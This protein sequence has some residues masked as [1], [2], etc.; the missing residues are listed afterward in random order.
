MV[1]SCLHGVRMQQDGQQVPA[2]AATMPW[3]DRLLFSMFH[4]FSTA[5]I[6]NG[7]LVVSL[8]DGRAFEYG[9]S[10]DVMPAM[11]SAPSWM[12]LPPKQCAMV[13]HNTDMFFKVITRHDSGLG[14]A[15]MNGDFDTDD[16]GAFMAVVTANARNIEASRGILGALNRI[17][18]K[19][20]Y[21][22]HLTRA[23]TVEGSKK[24]ISEHYDAGN[25][26]Y[27]L[28]LDS[29]LTYSA[30]IHHEGDSLYQAQMRKLDA[31]V[32]AAGVSAESHVLE[33]GCGW[34]SCAI[35]AVQ[36]TGCRWTGARRHSSCACDCT[37]C[38]PSYFVDHSG[39]SA[40][41]SNRASSLV[42]AP[43]CCRLRASCTATQRDRV[44]ASRCRRNNWWKRRLG[45]W[46]QAWNIASHCSSATI[47]TLLNGLAPPR[48]TLSLAAR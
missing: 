5:S 47:A 6:K 45:S 8:P 31:L 34:G 41:R 39:R 43:G 12:E 14:E 40:L 11:S 33:V 21:L 30:G 19:M 25:D 44:Q 28:F 10:A 4:K 7:H 9:D 15:Y 42:I 1:W 16:L 24:N 35:R 2:A 20:L 17:G 37:V 36:R 32:E 46:P 27:K 23:N 29:S 38:K 18:D 3:L 13:V 48:L 22:A 26:M